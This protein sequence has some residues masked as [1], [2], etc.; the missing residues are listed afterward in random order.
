MRRW[1]LVGV[2]AVLV[3]A[4]VLILP[5]PWQAGPVAP[6][7]AAAELPDA[8]LALPPDEPTISPPLEFAEPREAE[9]EETP[10]TTAELK[11]YLKR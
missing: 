11:T 5:W 6:A 8:R 9:A 4:L 3:A 2:G 10:L 1:V 7:E